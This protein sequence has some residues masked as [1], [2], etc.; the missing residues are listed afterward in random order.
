MTPYRIIPRFQAV[1]D[2]TTNPNTRIP[3]RAKCGLCG[4]KWKDTGSEYVNMIVDTAG[5]Q[6]FVCSPCVQN[7]EDGKDAN[8]TPPCQ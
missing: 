2:W 6:H 5:K 8:I 4:K 1:Q 7:L 3:C